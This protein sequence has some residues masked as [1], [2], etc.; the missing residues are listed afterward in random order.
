M[1]FLKN[2]AAEI[3]IY[4]VTQSSISTEQLNNTFN[5]ILNLS[6]RC[7]CLSHTPHPHFVRQVQIVGMQVSI[8]KILKMEYSSASLFY[9]AVVHYLYKKATASSKVDW[10]VSVFSLHPVYTKQWRALHFK[11]AVHFSIFILYTVVYA[12][13]LTFGGPVYK[14]ENHSWSEYQF[15]I[16]TFSYLH[17][18]Q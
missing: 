3:I 1:L 11:C 9:D 7:P 14:A 2:V 12:N 15:S 5:Y 18:K 16:F 6:G 17:F 4:W 8:L 13:T 10:C